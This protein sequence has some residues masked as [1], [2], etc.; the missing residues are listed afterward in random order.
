MTE[1]SVLQVLQQFDITIYS[2]KKK[3]VRTNDD[4]ESEL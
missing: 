4:N 3:S 1:K 2:I